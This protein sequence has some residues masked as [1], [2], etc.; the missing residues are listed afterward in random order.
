M[1]LVLLPTVPPDLAAQAWTVTA[2]ML[3][4]LQ[5]RLG[6]A[7]RGIRIDA[8]SHPAVVRSFHRQDLPAFVLLKHGT[9]VWRQQDL[10]ESESI[11]A[12]LLSKALP[13]SMPAPVA[14]A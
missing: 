12:E 3:N 14:Q 5:T 7:I 2:A 13:S 10:P 1:L 6:T 8:A 9:E 4:L 11:V